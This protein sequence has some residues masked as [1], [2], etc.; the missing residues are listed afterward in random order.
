MGSLDAFIYYYLSVAGMSASEADISW[1][2]LSTW[3]SYE[4]ESD[5]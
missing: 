2:V 5:I 1:V 3:R 4:R